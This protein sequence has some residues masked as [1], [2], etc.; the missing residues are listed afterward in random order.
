MQRTGEALRKDTLEEGDISAIREE[1]AFA[2][3]EWL[4]AVRKDAEKEY[5]LGDVS[6]ETLEGFVNSI[7]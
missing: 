6:V 3:E 4:N 5:G 1:C 2:R 7:R